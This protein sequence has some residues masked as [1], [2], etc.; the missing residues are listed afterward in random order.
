MSVQ[1]RPPSARPIALIRQP[2]AP[3]GAA[4]VHP[5]V[6]SGLIVSKCTSPAEGASTLLLRYNRYVPRNIWLGSYRYGEMP[7]NVPN[8]YAGR[9][10]LSGFVVVWSTI[11]WPPSPPAWS[12]HRVLASDL[13][14]VPLSWVPPQYWPGTCGTVA[15]L[16]NWVIRRP[17]A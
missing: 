4:P 2:R 3:L 7:K 6:R 17:V 14:S 12:N 9:L 16:V 5:V 10:G 8:T 1:C 13:R 11:T 15:M